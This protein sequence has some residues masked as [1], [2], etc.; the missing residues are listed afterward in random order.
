MKT[1]EFCRCLARGTWPPASARQ[2]AKSRAFSPNS[3]R[4]PMRKHSRRGNPGGGSQF[5]SK[6][7]L[8]GQDTVGYPRPSRYRS[9]AGCSTF[10]RLPRIAPTG[11]PNKLTIR[12]DRPKLTEYDI[13]KVENTEA[14]LARIGAPI[15][16]RL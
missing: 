16:S 11:R 3:P 6:G 9:A 14:P 12:G 5:D 13:T 2:R 1:H 10:S 15:E 4:L 7:N 8:S